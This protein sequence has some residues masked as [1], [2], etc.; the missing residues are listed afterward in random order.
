MSVSCRLPGGGEW[1]L[2]SGGW[3]WILSF[4][5]AGV[6]LCSCLASCLA[7][8]VHHWSLLAIGWSLVLVLRWRCM[9]ELSPIDITWSREVSGGPMSWTRLSHLRG[10]GLTP[11]WSTKTLLYALGNQKIHVTLFIVI[12][13]LLPWSETKP[14]TSPRHAWSPHPAA[15]QPGLLPLLGL[16]ASLFS[17]THVQMLS[18]GHSFTNISFSFLFFLFLFFFPLPSF[19]PS[20]LP[21]LHLSLSVSLSFL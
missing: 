18:P 17:N 1:C 12:S 4:C 13:T 5:W 20:F 9:G 2:C 10:S 11:C 19:L 14:T 3:C 16:L 21:P 6:G 7:W 8:G 15:T